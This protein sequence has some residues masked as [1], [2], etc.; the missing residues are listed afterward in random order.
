MGS[1]KRG[2]TR[3]V[4]FVGI[5]RLWSKKFKSNAIFFEHF[6]QNAYL[7]KASPQF[8]NGNKVV[9]RNR[10]IAAEHTPTYYR[11]ENPRF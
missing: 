7:F 4:V 1:S 3:W 11:H 8:N 6:A 9:P 10:T 5:L 2:T